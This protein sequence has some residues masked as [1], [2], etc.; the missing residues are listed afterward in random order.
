MKEEHEDCEH[1]YVN[2]ISGRCITCG[3]KVEITKK[4]YGK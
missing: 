3:Q 1:K 4:T 2:S